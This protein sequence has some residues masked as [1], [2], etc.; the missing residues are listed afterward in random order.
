MLAA[1][2][3][4]ACSRCVTCTHRRGQI[5][6]ASPVPAQAAQLRAGVP[7]SVCLS[8]VGPLGAIV[9]TEGSAPTATQGAR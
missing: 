2:S 5:C 3:I 7:V 9:A 6:A 8:F 4:P 1:M